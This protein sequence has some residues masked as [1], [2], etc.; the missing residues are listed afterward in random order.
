MTDDIEDEDRSKRA[1]RSSN[2]TFTTRVAMRRATESA[3]RCQSIE[4]SLLCAIII[5]HRSSTQ[6]LHFLPFFLAAYP[7]LYSS[8]SLDPGPSP[9][10]GSFLIATLHS[11]FV[12]P[13]PR[14]DPPAS[15]ILTTYDPSSLA[16][17]GTRVMMFLRSRNLVSDTALNAHCLL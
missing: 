2:P 10:L 13:H 8:S 1:R 16:L 4:R 11:S 7:S 17:P 14:L 5:S 3:S 15:L 6:S 9:S 12:L